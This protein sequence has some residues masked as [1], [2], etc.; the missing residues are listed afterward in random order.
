M[1]KRLIPALGMLALVALISQEAFAEHFSADETAMLVRGDVVRR[2]RP[3]NGKD[4]LFGGTGYAMIEASPDEIFSAI[5][6]W[7]V[8]PQIFSNVVESKLLAKRQGRSLVR[9]KIGHPVLS[10]TYHVEMTTDESSW[11]MRFHQVGGMANDLDDIYGYWRLFPVA[12]NRTIVAYVLN[13]KVPMGLVNLLPAS[14]KRMAIEG[15][16]G[17]PAYLREWMDKHPRSRNP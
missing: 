15:L 13:V 4:G 1:S 16:L 8:Y 5:Q 12:E 2:E 3:H 7:P 17:V 11:T 9:M 14:F 10:V 6:N